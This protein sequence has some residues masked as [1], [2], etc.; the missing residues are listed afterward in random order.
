MGEHGSRGLTS[1][2]GTNDWSES[3]FKRLEK[4]KGRRVTGCG[5]QSK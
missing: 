4:K 5:M 3:V 2:W 1:D